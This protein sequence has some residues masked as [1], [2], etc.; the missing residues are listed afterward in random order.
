MKSKIE[1]FG[2]KIGGARKDKWK[3]TGIRKEDLA[4]MTDIERNTYIKK[5][6]VW[7]KPD[8]VA[9]VNG[10]IPQSVAYFH[11]VVR[12]SI[13]IAPDHGKEEL[14]VEA[15]GKVRDYLDNVLDD[16]AIEEFRWTI[17]GDPYFVSERISRTRVNI[18][19][20]MWAIG[21]RRFLRAMQKS[22]WE[23]RRKAEARKFGLSGDDMLLANADCAIVKRI[24]EKKQFDN[25]YK[26]GY[27]EVYDFDKREWHVISGLTCE[28]GLSIPAGKYMLFYEKEYKG[29]F[30]SEEA[31]R[32]VALSFIKTKEENSKD[33]DKEETKRKGKESF[34]YRM[35]NSLT[36]SNAKEFPEDAEGEDFLRTFGFYGGEFGNWVSNTERQKNL[37]MAYI[38]FK[39]LAKALEL[40]PSAISLGG[41]LSIA[42][43]SRGKGNALAH[44][45]PARKC[46]ALT[47]LKGAGSLAHEWIHGLD[48][49][50]GYACGLNSSFTKANGTRAKKSV[51]PSMNELLYAMRFVKDGKGYYVSNTNFYKDS[52]RMD[53]KFKRS[54]DYWSSDCELLARAGAVYIKDKL[55]SMGITDDYLCGHA[56]LA[57]AVDDK[58]NIICAYPTGADRVRINIVFDKVMREVRKYFKNKDKDKEKKDEAK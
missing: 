15:I 7:P 45:E 23:M 6:M 16:E 46:I 19:D 42:F 25:A 8:Y 31:A 34:C 17:I 53:R 43:G 27:I 55:E 11:K 20:A 5:D 52:V 3:S 21:G 18:S 39:N 33:E 47:K 37:N 2:K 56:E 38:S 49:I 26:S 30:D 32:A 29:F 9:M 54:G 48:T 14:Y 58:G 1:D 12:D 35:L 40:P 22:G 24:D 13:A 10:G 36:Q 4:T 41:E 50:L 44:F 28:E 57:T 51:I